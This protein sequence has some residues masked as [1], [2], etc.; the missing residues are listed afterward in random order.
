VIQLRSL[1]WK[2]VFDDDSPSAEGSYMLTPRKLKLVRDKIPL[3]KDQMTGLFYIAVKISKVRSSPNLLIQ[4]EYSPALLA[5]NVIVSPDVHAN[6]DEVVAVTM[7][8][9]HERTG[10][11]SFQTLRSML[12]STRNLKI[13]GPMTLEPCPICDA[14]KVQKSKWPLH[15]ETDVPNVKPAEMIH[16]DMHGPIRIESMP[17]VNGGGR[18]R[19]WMSSVDEA[20]VFVSVFYETKV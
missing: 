13:T 5:L 8:Q 9:L 1:G 2:I 17:L 7:Q 4:E 3:L 15:S 10:H 6:E 19:Y 14:I 11:A 12:Q 20:E 16:A 18:S